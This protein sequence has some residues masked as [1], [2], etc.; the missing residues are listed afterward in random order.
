MSANGPPSDLIVPPGLV[1]PGMRGDAAPDSVLAQLRRDVTAKR[2]AKTFT[3]EWTLVETRL[4]ATYG[5]LGLDE[6]ERYI[7]G[8]QLDPLKPLTGN[9]EVMARACRAIEIRDADGKWWVIED[10]AGPVT[11]D[12]RLTRR[13]GWERPG[14]EYRY[15][16]RDVYEGMFDADGFALMAHQTRVLQALGLVEAEVGMDLSTSGSPT[17]SAQPPRSG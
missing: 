2:E 8:A 3:F 6:T 7:V 13:L 15:S 17:P 16:V 4:R 14:D 11:F 5:T 1:A 12:D 9:L 10:D